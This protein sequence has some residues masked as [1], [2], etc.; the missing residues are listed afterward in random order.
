M[1][2]EYQLKRHTEL[3]EGQNKQIKRIL[4]FGLIFAYILLVNILRPYSVRIENIK[5]QLNIT[6]TEISETVYNID[7]LDKLTN[8]IRSVQSI[9]DEQPWTKEKDN[10]I[11]KYRNMNISGAPNLDQYQWEADLTVTT[12][13]TMV[14]DLVGQPFESFLKDS[15]FIDDLPLLTK[16]LNNLPEAVNDWTKQNKGR[17]WYLTL[18]Q[19][20]ATI[21]SLTSSLADHLLDIS[22]EI[23]RAASKIEVEKAQLTEQ[24]TILKI[25]IEEEEEKLPETLDAEMKKILPNWIGGIITLEQMMLY[26]FFIIGIVIYAIVVAFELTK[27]YHFMMS[28]FKISDDISSDTALSSLW[29]LTNRGKIGTIITI[30]IYVGFIMLMWYFYEQGYILFNEWQLNETSKLFGNT[31]IFAGLWLGR[32]ILLLLIVLVVRRPYKNDNISNSI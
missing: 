32:A 23:D 28:G 2:N 19:K 31:G 9:I 15:S 22:N 1:K 10:L 12:I 24:V 20:E 27:H 4:L 3:W 7:N 18:N 29:T 13:G 14:L 26:P 17:R 6:N 5:T 11:L 30:S 16:E 21:Q 25:K 8:T